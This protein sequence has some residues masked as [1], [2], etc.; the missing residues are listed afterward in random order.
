MA[1]CSKCGTQIPEGA[2]FCPSCGTAASAGGGSTSPSAPR[3][4]GMQSNVAALL[5]Y[6][7]IIAIVFLLVEPFK[8]DKFVRFHAFQSI[9]YWIAVIV[10]F[11]LIGMVFPLSIWVLIYW[12]LRMLSFILMIFLMYKAYNNEKFKLPFIGDLAEKQV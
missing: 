7:V 1:F 9:F 2:A 11:M 4:S 3:T 8:N 5:S 6:L 10:I 12:P